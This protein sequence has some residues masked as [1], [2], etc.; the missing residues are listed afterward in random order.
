M[1]EEGIINV[2]WVKPENTI[3]SYSEYPDFRGTSWRGEMISIKISEL[4]K[5]Y[6]KQF[7][8]KLT[9]EQIFEIAQTS[10]EYQ[11]GDKIRWLTEWNVSF[12][13]PYDE[14]NVDAMEF[15][16]KTLEKNSFIV[17][18]TKKNKSTILKKNASE[19]SLNDNQSLVEDESW[20]LYKGVYARTANVLLEWGLSV[21][22]I[23]PQ[24]PTESGEVEFPYSFYMYQNQD[25][26][27]LAIPEKIEEPV[28]QMIVARLKIQQLVAKMKPTGAAINVDA[29]QELDLGLA[30]PTT[31][32]EA[33][34]IYDQTGELYFR[35]RDAEG[36]PIPVPVTEL[37]NAGFINQLQGLIQLYQ[38]HY[39]VLKDELGEDPNLIQRATTPRVAAGNVEVAQ[40]QANDATNYM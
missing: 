22:M 31:P 25:M 27:N 18:E 37:A 35:G 32:W 21:N 11:N 12:I 8:G 39:Q 16:V 15:Y 13:R 30:D 34:K 33:K 9:E 2:K 1:D 28:E 19:I 17:T 3:Y 40:Q 26:R 7:G 10:K 36:N 29:L 38:F 14:W 4:R 24:D 23:R 20:V 5:K 6:G